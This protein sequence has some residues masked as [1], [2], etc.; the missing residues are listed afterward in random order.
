MMV[1]FSYLEIQD[2]VPVYTSRTNKN[3]VDSITYVYFTIILHILKSEKMD[4][5]KTELRK[6]LSLMKPKIGVV[7]CGLMNDRQFVTNT[8]IQSIRYSGGLPLILPLIRSDSAISEYVETC[9][10]F[11]FCGGND[12]TP[13]LFGEEPKNGIGKT[14]LTLDLFQIRLMKAV[15]TTRKP[16]LAICRGMQVYNVAC[17]GTVY[18]DISLQPGTPLNH[19]QNSYSRSEVS[20]K[21]TIAPE[22][23]LRRYIG[24]SLDVNSYH[25]QSVGELGEA[26]IVSATASDGTVEAIEMPNHPFAIGV[27]WHPE[28]MYR[29]ST[30]MRELFSEFVLHSR[31]TPP[32]EIRTL[33]EDLNS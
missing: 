29:T 28:C 16:M 22:T 31:L 25:H 11:L 8:Y 4:E 3:L 15:L 14:D 21:I 12:I 19:M 26:L 18:Q 9:D 27:Q 13:L 2:R 20:H 30:E 5:T 1:Y 24:S 7:V 17:G 10:G 23:Q 6:D 32:T 33:E